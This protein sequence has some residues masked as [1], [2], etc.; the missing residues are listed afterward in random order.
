MNVN[1]AIGLTVTSYARI[2]MSKFKNNNQLIGNLYYSDTD[3]IFCDKPL[4]DKFVGK[5]LGQMKLEHLLT[6]FVALGPKVYGGICKDG[7]S[8]TK[9][10]GLKNKLTFNELESLL[11]KNYLNNKF[12]QEKWY[13]SLIKG[14]IKI[15]ER[16]YKL[17]VT[18][19]K[20]LLIFKNNILTSTTSIELKK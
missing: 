11:D 18:E 8:F 10:K 14:N 3:S 1:I 9:V 16:P 13:K 12:T 4:P 15:K 6:K 20:R 2:I 5:E 17:K 19:N 7:Y